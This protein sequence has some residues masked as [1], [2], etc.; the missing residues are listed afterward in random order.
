M[1]C[2]GICPRYKINKKG[3]GSRYSQ[4]QSRCQVCAIY[5]KFD[6]LYCPCCGYRL[7][8]KPRNKL[9]KAKF[10][11]AIAITAEQTARQWIG[12]EKNPEYVKIF[13]AR[14]DDYK[15]QNKLEAFL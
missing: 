11:E 14:L 12:I 10:R 6:G 2:K 8:K 3:I 13:N 4:G 5:I 9:Y 15:K 7:R 1:T